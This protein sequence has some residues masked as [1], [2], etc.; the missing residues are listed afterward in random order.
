MPLPRTFHTLLRSHAEHQP[1]ASTAARLGT[2]ERVTG[3][4]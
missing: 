2:D 1:E 3:S 4:L